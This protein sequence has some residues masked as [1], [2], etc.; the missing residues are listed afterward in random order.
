ML[1]KW[2]STVPV[3]FGISTGWATKRLHLFTR[4][5]AILCYL[6]VR[7]GTEELQ[8]GA[9]SE[10]EPMSDFA[11]TDQICRLLPNRGKILPETSRK[12]H[13]WNTNVQSCWDGELS[14]QFARRAVEMCI[15]SAGW[16]GNMLERYLNG[17]SP[18][19]VP[20]RRVVLLQQTERNQNML[21]KFARRDAAALPPFSR[22]STEA[23]DKFNGA[24]TKLLSVVVITDG[25]W[26]QTEFDWFGGETCGVTGW[27]VQSSGAHT[28]DVWKS[29]NW[30]P[31]LLCDYCWGAAGPFKGFAWTIVTLS[32]LSYLYVTNGK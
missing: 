13:G 17:N 31:K 14:H 32:Q 1:S 28:D 21:S 7:G 2:V 9:S 4:R 10:T 24:T 16:D 29:D 27:R 15:G 18:I 12:C 22:Q 25:R 20:Q 6:C 5:N 23:G 11:A 3:L 19:H 30:H 8:V 26:L